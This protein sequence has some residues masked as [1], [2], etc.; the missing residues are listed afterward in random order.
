MR[1]FFATLA[2]VWVVGIVAGLVYAQQQHIPAWAAAAILPAFLVELAFYAL[3][4]FEAPRE[5][6]RGRNALLCG[7][8]L[9]PYLILSIGA[10]NFSW[11]GLFKL[12]ILVVLVVFWFQL[13]PRRPWVDLAFMV[14]VVGIFMGKT[15]PAIYLNP[16]GKPALD[17]L[18]RLM[19]AR[20]GITAVLLYRGSGNVN[21]GFIPGPRE[22]L[23]GLRCFVIL[24]V[25]V[26]PIAF[27]VGFVTGLN[28]ALG[29]K[30]VAVAVGT[31]LLILW[32]VAL[33]EEF[34]FRG[35]LQSAMSGLLRNESAGLV[36][37]S[38]LF[39]MSH[40]PFRG[41]PN[42]RMAVVATV[43]GLIYGKAYQDGKGV[44]AAM[45]THALTV[46]TWRV[47]LS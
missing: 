44:R 38:V 37:T 22:W 33:Y 17:I 14:M 13:L 12:T 45:V 27:G 6:L 46:T 7:S 28:P 30:S 4:G 21:F 25:F 42:W 36:V 29:L 40:L 39:G 3:P 2:A 10:G 11:T 9:L 16:L 20:L 47:L 23:I 34:F 41:F 1:S 32:S 31:F 26:A 8:A 18:G 15:F 5:W 24:A 35:L 43:A 19:L